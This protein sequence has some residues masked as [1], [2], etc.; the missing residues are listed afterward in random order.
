MAVHQRPVSRPSDPLDIPFKPAKVLSATR[1]APTA[2]TEAVQRVRNEFVEMRGFSPTLAQAARLF[3]LPQD[4]CATVLA[5][6]AGEG[7]IS[8][9][10]DG[11]YRLISRE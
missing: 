8:R 4:V 2:S 9:T 1:S 3:Q 5:R 6:L 11:R 10:A 7:F